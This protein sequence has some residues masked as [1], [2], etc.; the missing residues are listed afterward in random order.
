[1]YE[2]GRKPNKSSNSSQQKRVKPSNFL[3]GKSKFTTNFPFVKKGSKAENSQ[4][5][6]EGITQ[7]V[8]QPESSNVENLQ[9]VTSRFSDSDTESEEHEGITQQV[10]Q[11]E[12]SN[13]ENLQQVTSGFSDSDTESEIENETESQDKTSKYKTV[14]MGKV[15]KAGAGEGLSTSGLTDCTAVAV[16]SNFNTESQIYEEM[17]MFHILGSHVESVSNTPGAMSVLE[18]LAKGEYTV[19]IVYGADSSSD[20]MK[21]MIT[22]QTAIAKLLNGAKKKEYHTGRSVSIDRL[23]KV[24]VG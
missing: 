23:G 21:S 5:E 18:N 3:P 19:V 4:A 14:A 12:S 11:P 1:M 8:Q 20:T 24:T 7:Q 22:R 13:V 16:L 15:E 2:Q 9:Q 17:G 6:N 10:Q